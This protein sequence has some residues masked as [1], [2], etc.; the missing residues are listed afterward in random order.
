VQTN[1]RQPLLRQ[2]P[3]IDSLLNSPQSTRL[4]DA[5]GRTLTI[6]ALRE[7]LAETRLAIQKEELD[8]TPSADELIDLGAGWLEQFFTPTLIPVINAS[9]VIV[10]TNL[11]R[12]PLSL[13]ALSSIQSIS[14]G[15]STLEY[16]IDSGSRGSRSIHAAGLLQK[17]T[18]TE[19]ALVVN[20]NAAAVLLM[21]S[22]LCQGKEVIIS[23]GQL[24]EIGGGF[25]VPDVM[26]QSGA[27][28]VEVGTTNRTHL[29]DYERA[30]TPDTA[31]I[32]V[33][34][35][36]NYK[37]IGFTSE[38]SIEELAQLAHRHNLPLLFDQ[39]SG[40]LYDVS[41]FG[42]DHEPTV[43][44][45]LQGG[46]DIVAF[47]G[48]KLL[49]GPQAGILCGK[50]DLIGVLKQHPLARAIRADKTCLAA[51]SATL[52]HYLREEALQEI[53]VWMMIARD[54][55]DLE[56]EADSWVNQLQQAGIPAKT[57]DGLSRIGGGSLPGSSLPTKL[58]AIQSDTADNLAAQLRGAEHPVIGRIQE[59]HLLLDPRTV[60]PYQAQTL[61]QTVIEQFSNN[62]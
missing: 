46:A 55:D 5:F 56:A 16:D 24:V 57:Q 40:A 33:A 25:R 35:H 6:E 12:A 26:I 42:L 20:N 11:G 31:A 30:I 15:Y 54:I 34:H 19:D 2:L 7:V 29:R 10:H 51:L 38:P 3:S 49:G 44:E 41:Q 62:E 1:N 50:K 58:V 17:L 21:L 60:L 43:I 37:I 23:R 28:L 13:S 52:M 14:K 45:G 48:D 61:V 4:Q 9:G 32:M 18:G 22:G 47:S 59:N 53:P 27:R 39:G 8:K 36:S